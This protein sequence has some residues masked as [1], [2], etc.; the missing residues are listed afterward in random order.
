[1]PSSGVLSRS[2]WELIVDKTS[3]RARTVTNY[4]GG[5]YE[6]PPERVQMSLLAQKL[7]KWALDR[8]TTPEMQSFMTTHG[9]SIATL[10]NLSEAQLVESGEQDLLQEVGLFIPH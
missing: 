7:A 6:H 5:T 4:T 2:D 3:K 10:T 8:Q 9:V 1:M